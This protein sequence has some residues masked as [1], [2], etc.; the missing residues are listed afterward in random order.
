MCPRRHW[1]GMGERCGKANAALPGKREA[2]RL[3]QDLVVGM[4]E[5]LF[6]QRVP[7]CSDF[8][9]LHHI[10]FFLGT[11]RDSTLH[12]LTGQ[13]VNSVL[14][15][16]YL[17][18]LF[19]IPVHHLLCHRSS[20][21][22]FACLLIFVPS[23]SRKGL[24]VTCTCLSRNLGGVKAESLLPQVT[25]HTVLSKCRRWDIRVNPKG[26]HN[27]FLIMEFGVIKRF[28]KLVASTLENILAVS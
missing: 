17:W 10:F 7:S 1:E 27:F 11:N 23:T 25:E 5:A 4:W 20:T 26:P 3:G 2:P 28:K 9:W 13:L 18:T 24:G 21:H 12:I 8:C 15:W 6:L 14:T 22:T 16:F 19:L